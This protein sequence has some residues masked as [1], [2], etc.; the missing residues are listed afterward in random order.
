M[1][2][3]VSNN[4]AETQAVIRLLETFPVHC[5]L[6]VRTD[7]S[8]VLGFIEKRAP[9]VAR[10]NQWASIPN[11][12]LLKRLWELICEKRKQT[13]LTFEHV[14]GH[15]DCYGNNQADILAVRASKR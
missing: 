7:S 3:T 10:N 4:S 11:G 2:P 9:Y 12:N 5:P 1:Q 13:T 14:R 6:C 15:S 8:Y